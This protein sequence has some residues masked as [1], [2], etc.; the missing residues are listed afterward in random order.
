LSE[1]E[2]ALADARVLGHNRRTLEV[3]VI[4]RALRVVAVDLSPQYGMAA[5]QT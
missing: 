3:A 4:T 5:F 2:R 1:I